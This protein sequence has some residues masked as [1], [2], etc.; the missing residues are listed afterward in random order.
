[1]LNDL[2]WILT[3]AKFSSDSSLSVTEC[4]LNDLCILQIDFFARAK[5]L[6]E[7]PLLKKQYDSDRQELKGFWEQQEEERVR[8]I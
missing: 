3:P 4:P 2:F 7:L 5:R 6:E 1:M 8:K